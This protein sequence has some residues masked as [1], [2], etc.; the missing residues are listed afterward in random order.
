[1]VSLP[2]ENTARRII[3][4]PGREFLQGTE[5]TGTCILALPASRTVRNK[6]LLLK[7]PN[8]PFVLVAQTKI[9]IPSEKYSC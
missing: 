2:R 4:K 9:E 7:S 3:C 1:M 6:F 8:D 5:Y